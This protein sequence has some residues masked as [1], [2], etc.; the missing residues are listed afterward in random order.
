MKK[1]VLQLIGSFNQGGSERQAIALT[2]LLTTDGTFEVSAATL[3]SEGILRPEIEKLGLPEIPEFPLTSFYNANFIKQ[4]RACAKYLKEH[5]ID[6][7]H[8][9]DF[10]TNVFG[11]AAASLAG[12]KARI[13]SKRETGGMRSGSQDL[14]EKFAFAR[15]H[16]I[17]VNSGSVK[18]YLAVRGIPGPKIHLIYN[19]LDI[20]RFDVTAKDRSVFLQKHLLPEDE[21]IHLIS[22]VANLRHDVKNIPMLLRAAKGVVVSDDSAH[23]VIAGEGE[24][25]NMLQEQTVEFGIAGNVHFIGRCADVPELLTNSFACVLTSTAEGFSNAILEYMAA[26]KPVV[27]TNV[28]GASEAVVHDR[29]GYLID[30]NDDRSLAEHLL[31]LLQDPA[32]AAR[33]GGEGKRIVT[34]K[35][36]EA[37]QLQQTVELYNS[38]LR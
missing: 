20:K 11:M 35:F 23:F 15:A 32:K 17:V 10:Y 24:L 3:N 4:V 38:L 27:A 7:I 36:S 37:A 6:L 2:R 22:L 21:G 1:R 13:A 19:G 26:G 5:Q 30:S 28:G 12:L 33:L 29:S 16:A 14:V 25:L 31:D 34:S 18:N 9:H 8:T